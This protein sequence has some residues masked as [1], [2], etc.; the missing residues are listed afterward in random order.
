MNN[1]QQSG[2]LMNSEKNNIKQTYNNPEKRETN[3]HDTRKTKQTRNIVMIS[4]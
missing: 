3:K 1:D 4:S 2:K